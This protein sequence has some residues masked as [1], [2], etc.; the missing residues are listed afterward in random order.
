MNAA[1]RDSFVL[2]PWVLCLLTFLLFTMKV[3]SYSWSQA[4]MRFN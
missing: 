2:A 1:G 3:A 4:K